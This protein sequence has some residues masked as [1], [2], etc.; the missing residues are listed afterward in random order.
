MMP[1]SV[2]GKLRKGGKGGRMQTYIRTGINRK[3][4]QR[5]LTRNLDPVYYR[6]P[7]TV[8]ICLPQC[9]FPSD[10]PEVCRL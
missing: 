6:A 9:R 7:L 8:V 5:Y 1:M 2:H 3:P 4:F 10:L